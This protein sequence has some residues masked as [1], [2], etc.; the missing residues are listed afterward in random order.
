VASR[1]AGAALIER[2]WAAAGDHIAPGGEVL[3]HTA[4]AADPWA[5]HGGRPGAVVIAR[6]TPAGER[7]FA[8]TRW[9]PH[10]PAAR[11]LVEIPLGP[12]R[13]YVHRR[14]LPA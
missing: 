3:A 7:G 11:E 1:A 10:A 8:I 5:L 4:V 14:D 13:P 2:F 9:R 12:G 6:Y